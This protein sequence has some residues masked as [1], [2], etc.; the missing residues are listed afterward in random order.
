ML[1]AGR[2]PTRSEEEQAARLNRLLRR[3]LSLSLGGAGGAVI[4]AAGAVL[5]WHFGDFRIEAQTSVGMFPLLITAMPILCG[6]LG[7]FAPISGI[8]A[9]LRAP[10]R[11]TL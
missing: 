7:A 5:A 2:N 3:S 4:G 9:F 10:H 6:I 11:I 8:L 1:S